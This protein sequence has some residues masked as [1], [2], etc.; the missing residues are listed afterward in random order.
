[1]FS[2][3]FQQAYQRGLQQSD[4]IF[5]TK[6]LESAKTVIETMIDTLAPSGYMKYAPDGHFVFATFASAF[7]LKVSPYPS[8]QVVS[9]R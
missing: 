7:L 9:G 4:H 1:M 6:C 5:F 3:G 2:F 8:T